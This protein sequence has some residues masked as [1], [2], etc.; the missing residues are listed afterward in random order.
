MVK[1]SRAVSLRVQ[2]DV[3]FWSDSV[4]CEVPP[5]RGTSKYTPTFSSHELSKKKEKCASN[6]SDAIVHRSMTPV[7]GARMTSWLINR[8]WGGAHE[9]CPGWIRRVL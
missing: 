6:P 9:F 3:R 5:D 2:P 8:S 4:K 1:T 7:R